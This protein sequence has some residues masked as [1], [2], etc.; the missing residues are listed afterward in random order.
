VQRS[1]TEC[2]VNECDRE[3]SKGEAMAQRRAAAPHERKRKERKKETM[4]ERKREINKKGKKERKNL[5]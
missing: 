5:F 2:G 3:A 1:P 4:K